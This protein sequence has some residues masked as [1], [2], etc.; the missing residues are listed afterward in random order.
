MARVVA[1][2]MLHHVTQRGTNRQQVFYSDRDREVYLAWLRE[3]SERYGLSVAGYCLMANHVHLIVVPEKVDS[4]ANAIG[5]THCRYAAYANVGL[6]R[7]GH[8][9]QNRY[10]SCALE[11]SRLGTALRYVERNPLRAGLV[12]EAVEWRWSSARAHALGEPDPV[13]RDE[14]WWGEYTPQEWRLVLAEDTM[15][16]AET[17]LRR[18]TYTGRP[19][20]SEQFVESLE[21]LL[22]RRLTPSPGGRAGKEP[23]A[24][25]EVAM[26]FRQGV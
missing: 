17:E 25:Q 5:K 18:Q 19:V 22:G 6:G 26:T 13:L 12:R 8:F 7:S 10:F 14:I 11:S 3:S 9:W 21:R 4:L 16:E 23:A 2:G 15:S 1:P 24:D 20:G